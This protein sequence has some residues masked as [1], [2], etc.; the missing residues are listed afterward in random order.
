MAEH[1]NLAG[2]PD[3]PR[4][5]T[6]EQQQFFSAIKEILE[7]MAGRFDAA[8]TTPQMFTGEYVGDG[9]NNRLIATDVK[10]R[11]AK[12]WIHPDSVTGD[13]HVVERLFGDSS[14]WGAFSLHHTP[15]ATHEHRMIEEEG[16]TGVQSGGFKVSG[17][18]HCN[19]SNIKYSWMILG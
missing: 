18:G 9:T 10:P 5:A 14:D 8:P 4:D 12:V 7:E 3:I 2:L 6:I 16:I 19:T 17:T 11:Y 13:T 15:T 1:E